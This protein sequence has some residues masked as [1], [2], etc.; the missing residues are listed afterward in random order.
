MYTHL[1]NLAL[2][3][4]VIDD[5]SCFF[6]ENLETLDDGGF[7]IIDTTAGLS[8]FKETL[9]HHFLANFEIENCEARSH[10]QGNMQI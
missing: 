7:V 4:V 6:F 9:F 2:L 10:L 3:G 5:G 8:T 1:N